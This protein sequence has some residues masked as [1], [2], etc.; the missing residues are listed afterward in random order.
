MDG[1]NAH[2]RF[3]N[4]GPKRYS[5]RSGRN[6]RIPLD[7]NSYQGCF[8]KTHGLVTTRCIHF[9]I[10]GN[11]S[12]ESLATSRI[13]AGQ[14]YFLGVSKFSVKMILVPLVLL[15]LA[16]CAEVGG[17]FEKLYQAC[18]NRQPQTFIA[19]LSSNKDSKLNVY[20]LAGCSLQTGQAEILQASS[21]TPV[22]EGLIR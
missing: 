1:H 10:I 6:N 12:Q 3:L 19:L 2:F 13:L 18:Q 16:R 20:R 17:A 8:V 7:L 14:S 5:L 9:Y 4:A 22:W 15:T 11:L 21:R